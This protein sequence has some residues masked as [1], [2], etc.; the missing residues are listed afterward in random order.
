ML[1]SARAL[2][3][4]RFSVTLLDTDAVGR[5]DLDQLRRAITPETALVSIQ[6]ANQEIGTLQDLQAIADICRERETLFHTD[7]T[8]AYPRVPLNMRDL[9]VDLITLTSH[10][11]CVVLMPRKDKK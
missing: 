8:H 1:H 5:V 4:D 7:A 3:K 11:E 2:E 9:P 10:V 6:A